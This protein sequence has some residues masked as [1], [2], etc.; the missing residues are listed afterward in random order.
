MSEWT[1]SFSFP[2]PMR[3]PAERV[4][5][6]LT[7]PA[8]LTRW[9]AEH[10]ELEPQTGGAFRFWGRSSYGAP[11]RRQAIQRFTAFE[12]G[13]RIAFTWPLH[14]E[15]SEVTL[16]VAPK[17]AT[18]SDLS[19]T[20]RFPAMPS[21]VQRFPHLI[22]DLWR[23]VLGNLF[24]FL[25]G[26]EPA[27]LPDFADSKPVVRSSIF[28]A[29]PPEK[30]YRALVEPALLEKWMGGKAEVDP[31]VGGKYVLG[32]RYEVEGRAVAGG[33]TQILELIPNRRVVTDWTD[34]RGD[35]SVPQQTITWELE[36]EASGTRVTLTH[37]G[38]LRPVD[39]SDYGMG[40]GHFLSQLKATAE[41]A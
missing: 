15:V 7:D 12:P 19:V 38:F 36:P 26:G 39:I 40:W 35:P 24:S 8:D 29:A 18:T 16:T 32:W 21:N 9:F 23:L 41:N 25:I 13:R 10:V 33:P 34:W 1:H 6:A 28:I 14:G 2:M 3:A 37:S 4:F 22:E 5:A 31:R 27:I 17:D 11:T 30:V 20:H